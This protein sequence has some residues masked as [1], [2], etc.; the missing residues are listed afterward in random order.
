LQPGVFARCEHLPG[1]FT[2]PSG[3]DCRLEL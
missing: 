1:N 3:H 2:D